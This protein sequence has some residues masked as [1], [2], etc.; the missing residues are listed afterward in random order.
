[1]KTFTAGDTKYVINDAEAR[2]AVA[3]LENN[4]IVNQSSEPTAESNKIWIPTTGGNEVEVPEMDEFNELKSDLD[5]IKNKNLGL[6]IE[7]GM[8]CVTY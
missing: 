4:L 5:E 6:V 7:N 8:L 1:M 3:D 2:T